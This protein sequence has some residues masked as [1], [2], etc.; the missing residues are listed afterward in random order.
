LSLVKTGKPSS[1]EAL[2]LLSCAQSPNRATH[3]G[4]KKEEE[5]AMSSKG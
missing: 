5:A 2:N 4:K 1:P 3:K